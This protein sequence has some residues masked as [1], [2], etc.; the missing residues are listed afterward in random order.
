MKTTSLI[1]FLML[2]LLLSCEGE[3]IDYS[4]I[5]RSIN[6][7]ARIEG[8]K[9]R[10]TNDTWTDGDMIGIY[11]KTAAQ[12][13]SAESALAKNAKYATRGDG[14]FSPATVA[15]DVKFPIDGSQVDFIA[16]YPQ[17]TVSTAFEYS[18]D[19]SNQ[20]DQAA[21]DL[22]YSDNARNLSK[23][24]NA[25]NLSFSHKLSKIIVN[26]T[27]TGETGLSDVTATIKGLNTKAKLSLIDGTLGSPSSK[28]NIRMKVNSGGN[29]A[30]A[31][32]LPA[33]SLTGAT[34]EITSGLSGYTYDLAS[35]TNITRFEPGYRYT[36]NVTLDTSQPLTASA[37][38]SS[39]TEG[40]SESATLPKDF[41][42]YTP[43]GAGT[44][45]NPYTVQ[46]AQNLKELSGVWVRGYIVGYYS[47]TTASSF[48]ND[49]NAES[50]KDTN[51]AIAASSSETNGANTV[52]VQLSTTS[53][54]NAL[55]LKDKPGNLGKE[56]ILKGNLTTYYGIS[57]ITNISDFEWVSP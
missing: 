36:Y 12:P 24:S 9:T 15:N 44:P 6:V 41:E 14:F 4:I 20:N 51:L 42:V 17:G 11:M 39:W 49:V 48:S 34:M 47:G 52:S 1:L 54:K 31:I 26:L 56:L 8:S 53:I 55:N 32:V 10:A 3:R 16:Y 5:N 22:L 46:D 13:L 33:A 30:E 18:I 45:E 28:G 37:T 40:P 25:V 43:T 57:G 21:I 19:L 7:N 23:T 35:T 27:A 2:A 38:I 29:S 50:I